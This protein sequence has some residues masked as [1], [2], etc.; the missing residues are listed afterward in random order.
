MEQVKITRSIIFAVLFILFLIMFYQ[1]RYIILVSLIGVGIGVLIMP[2]LRVLN[3]KFH[4]PRAFSGFLVMLGIILI[5][6]VVGGSIY[7][8]VSD[9]MSSLIQRWPSIVANLER[10][11]SDLFFR[12]PWLEGQISQFELGSYLRQ[13]IAKIFKGFQFLVLGLSLGLFVLVLA[14]Y[15]A[16]GGEYYYKSLIEAFPRPK[17]TKAG[18]VLHE[19]AEVLRGWFRAQLIDMIIIGILTGVGL[20]I[21]GVE[22]WAVFG[23][24]TAVLGIIPYLGI[25]LVIFSAS[26]ITL[27]S[28]ASQLPW[29]LLVF[30][31][32]QQ[33]EGNVI[34]PLVLKGKA[35]LPVVPLL[36]FM[37]ILGTFLGILG[38][39]IAP[40][41][42]AVLRTLYIELYLPRVNQRQELLGP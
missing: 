18:D 38:V 9:Q 2:V 29:L 11:I 36:I 3:I 20:W 1:A 23:L 40:P 39:F 13:S 32:T 16:I 24:L 30:V 5:L 25:F 15:T 41:L 26:L 17:R 6:G 33:L 10:W 8:L 34:L 12:Y 27:A 35:E 4:L 31:I 42:M 14:M 19:S 7:Y 22:Y 28:D 21:V 37:F